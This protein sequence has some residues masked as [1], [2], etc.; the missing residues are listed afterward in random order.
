[1][2]GRYQMLYDDEHQELCKIRNEINAK[3][4]QNQVN[5]GEIFPTNTVPIL[6]AGAQKTEAD[7]MIW[8]FPN[9]RSKGVIINA[10]SETAPQKP[11]FRDSLL[12]RRCIIPSS[13]FFEWKQ[14]GTKQKYLFEMPDAN[15][16]YMA[17]VYQTFGQ[18]NRFVILTTDANPSIAEIHHRMPLVLTKGQVDDWIYRQDA[19][20]SLLAQQPPL[21]KKRAI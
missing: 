4:G 21:L 20:L 14:D 1:M 15:C 12:K 17:G 19:A 10:R 3:Y 18:E 2:C 7:L 11:F 8:G 6:H 5:S 13:G 9:F 16:L